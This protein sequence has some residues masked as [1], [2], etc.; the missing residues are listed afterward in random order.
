MFI[1]FGDLILIKIAVLIIGILLCKEIFG[2]FQ[3]DLPSSKTRRTA[4]HGRSF[5]SFGL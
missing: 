2:R 5:F 1:T 3:N 4:R